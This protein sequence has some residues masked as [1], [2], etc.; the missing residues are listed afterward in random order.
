MTK[1][2]TLSSKKPKP[3]GKEITDS[4]FLEAVNL[5]EENK[6]NAVTQSKS[7][8]KRKCANS[9]CATKKSSNTLPNSPKPSTSGLKKQH[10]Q[11]NK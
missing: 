2:P 3:G 9:G 7:S 10:S 1:K 8:M 11:F 6:E 5:Y 4:S